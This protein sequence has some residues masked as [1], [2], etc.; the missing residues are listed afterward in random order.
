MANTLDYES[1]L[2]ALLSY[3]KAS[4]AERSFEGCLCVIGVRAEPPAGWSTYQLPG[5]V[6]MR[7]SWLVLSV[8]FAKRQRR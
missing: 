5:E 3:S 2:K 8:T 4:I 1:T 7:V 6:G